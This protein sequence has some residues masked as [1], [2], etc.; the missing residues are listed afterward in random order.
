M[1]VA[2]FAPMLAADFLQQESNTLEACHRHWIELVPSSVYSFNRV[3][4]PFGFATAFVIAQ[5]PELTRPVLGSIITAGAS[6][7]A[8]GSRNTLFSD[9]ARAVERLIP[10]LPPSCLR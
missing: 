3:D 9:P 1:G 10:I 8:V 5:P 2:M 6:V 7:A 4:T